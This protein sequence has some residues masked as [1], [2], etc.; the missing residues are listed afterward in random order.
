MVGHRIDMFGG[1]TTMSIASGFEL[2]M[3]DLYTLKPHSLPLL[4]F[5][6][7]SKQDYFFS[8]HLGSPDPFLHSEGTVLITC[9]QALPPSFKDLILYHVSISACNQTEAHS[10]TQLPLR[11]F[12]TP[13]GTYLSVSF[14]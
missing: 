13:L 14:R 12:Y 6:F 1:Y 7:F 11:G 2:V 8:T 4:L 3:E 9:M 10:R 5:P